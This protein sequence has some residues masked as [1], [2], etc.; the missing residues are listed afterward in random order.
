MTRDTSGINV[1]LFQA[2]DTINLFEGHKGG[3]K[4]SQ[5]THLPKEK[6]LP[7]CNQGKKMAGRIFQ[8]ARLVRDWGGGA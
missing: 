8:D 5:I 6:A 3:E 7:P 2:N 4:R 1:F